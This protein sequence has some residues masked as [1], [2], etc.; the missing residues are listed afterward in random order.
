MEAFFRLSTPTRRLQNNVRLDMALNFD[1]VWKSSW[2]NPK[3]V[4]Q[5]VL[6]TN[7]PS[8]CLRGKRDALWQE[9]SAMQKDVQWE[10]KRRRIAGATQMVSIVLPASK[11]YLFQLGAVTSRFCDL[12]ITVAPTVVPPSGSGAHLNPSMCVVIYPYKLQ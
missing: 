4:F 8:V 1:Q 7:C 12:L 11:T 9:L 5:R 3:K 2:S 6:D 10:A